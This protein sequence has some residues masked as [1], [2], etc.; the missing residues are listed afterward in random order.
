MTTIGSTTSG[1]PFARMTHSF[2]KIN[3]LNDPWIKVLKY[4]KSTTSRGWRRSVNWPQP[5]SMQQKDE[6]IRNFRTVTLSESLRRSTRVARHSR[7]DSCL[8]TQVNA[9]VPGSAAYRRPYA[10]HCISMAFGVV[11]YH[12]HLFI[13][14]P[15][16]YP[17]SRYNSSL[18]LS[19]GPGSPGFPFNV[20]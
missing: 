1:N 9:E 11:P 10:L 4:N 5:T 17:P 6:R 15:S 18:V 12:S 3:D 16:F 19:N 7:G 2:E 20:R 13:P 14:P 8:Q